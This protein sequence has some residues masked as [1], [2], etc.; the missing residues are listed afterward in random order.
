MIN[1]NNII[2]GN[3]NNHNEKWPYIPDHPYRILIIGGS[4]SRKTNTLFNLIN[5]QNDIDKIYLYARDLSESKYEYLIKNRE[6]AGIK[7]LNDSKAFIE[8]LN[9]MD[10]GY[11]NINDYNPNRRRKILI[12]FDDMIA[13]IMTNKKF[14]AI[15]KELFIRCRKINVSLVFITQSYFSVPK[16]V[17]FNSTHYFIMSIN[18]KRELQN[19]GINHSA[20]IDYKD[21]IKIYRERAKEPYDFLTIDTTLPSHNSLRFRKPLFDTLQNMTVTDQ[22]KI[23]D[24]KIKQNEAQYDLD[25]ETAK[26]SALS[27]NN[28]GKYE[29]LTGEDLDL[30]LSTVEQAKFEYSPLGKI[31][32]KGLSEED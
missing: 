31:F 1:L 32:N 11:K 22:I 24:R 7:H 25:R 27:S 26:I 28:L 14:Q 13:D 6:N 18:N 20:D 21:F 2:N 10:D 12:V 23:L 17:S 9:T 30:K 16:D 19:I 8:C 5:E 4:G 15:L 29:Y 3:N